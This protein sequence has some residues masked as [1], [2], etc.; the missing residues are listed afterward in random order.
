M[1]KALQ[2][3]LNIIARPQDREQS[4][5]TANQAIMG[6]L[7]K[8]ARTLRVC[9]HSLVAKGWPYGHVRKSKCYHNPIPEFNHIRGGK[10]K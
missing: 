1:S 4:L 8:L 10:E 9:G 7:S 6:S 2:T 5:R 3:W